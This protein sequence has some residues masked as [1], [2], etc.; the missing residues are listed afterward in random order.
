MRKYLW[1]TLSCLLA[2]AAPAF[3]AKSNKKAQHSDAMGVVKSVDAEKS[4]ITVTVRGAEKKDK[5]DETF[6]VAKDVNLSKL[7]PGD[8]VALML[9]KDGKS[10]EKIETNDKKK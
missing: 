5:K 9:S 3:A 1:L 8:R 4:T 7:K 10:V 2:V 6:T